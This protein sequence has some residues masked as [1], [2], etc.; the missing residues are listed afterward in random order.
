L[1]TLLLSFL[2][3]LLCSFDLSLCA[4]KWSPNA[5]V[6]VYLLNSP[7]FKKQYGDLLRNVNAFHSGI[8]FKNEDTKEELILDYNGLDV[9]HAVFPIVNGK[10]LEV[11]DEAV[12]QIHTK[13]DLTYWDE[14]ILILQSSGQIVNDFLCWA[15]TYNSTNSR[16]ELFAVWDHTKSRQE[17]LDDPIFSGSSCIDYVWKSI[18]VLRSLGATVASQY[19]ATHRD[20]IFFSVDQPPQR[21]DF[22]GPEQDRILKFYETFQLGLVKNHTWDEVVDHLMLLFGNDWY[23][24]HDGHYFKIHLSAERA[25]FV[26]D[27][28]VFPSPVPLDTLPRANSAECQISGDYGWLWFVGVLMFF[29]LIVLLVSAPIWIGALGVIMWKVYTKKRRQHTEFSDFQ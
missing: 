17:S 3:L 6:S 20:L 25:K 14:P 1:N 18:Q 19:K 23:T 28:M 2:L 8:Y 27:Y 15:P 21:I 7:L 11:H 16:Y 5:Q 26:F 22:S 4:T 29:G 9:L 13:L 12:V 10:S 24:R